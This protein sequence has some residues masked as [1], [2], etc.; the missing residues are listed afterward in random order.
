M[1]NEFTFVQDPE[2]NRSYTHAHSKEK[3]NMENSKG[4]V[5]IIGKSSVETVG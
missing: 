5:E 3:L 2:E 1:K 4:I